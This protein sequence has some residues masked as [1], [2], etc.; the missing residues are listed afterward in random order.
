[1]GEVPGWATGVDVDRPSA[2]RMYDYALGGSHNFEAD[3][4]ALL[5]AAKV[6]PDVMLSA[7]A[8]RLF[9]S[10]A[11]RFLVTDLG[12]TQFLDLGSGVPTVGNVHEVAQSIDPAARVVY[13]DIDPVAIAHAQAL[14]ADNPLATALRAD[15]REPATILAAEEVSLLDFSRPIAVLMLTVLHFVAD[16]EDPAALVRTFREATAPGSA[17]VLSHLTTD[18]D[19]VAEQVRDMRTVLSASSSPISPRSKPEIAGLLDSYELVEPGLV[20]VPSWR[21]EMD[22]AG[23]DPLATE[24]TRSAG[25][26]AVG[27][28]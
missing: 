16:E 18:A 1:M 3:R 5:G 17:L 6:F 11:V 21:P 28:R 24:P 25:F 27:R 4:Q 20:L 19:G 23:L 12:V 22:P 2:A 7:R 9:L 10:R 26:V 14:L 13:V 8:N 15:I